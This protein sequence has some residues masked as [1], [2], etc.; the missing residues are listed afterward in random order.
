MTTYR[1]EVLHIAL[2]K[3][4]VSFVH[5]TS[6]HSPTSFSRLESH[7]QMKTPIVVL[8]KQIFLVKLVFNSS[9]C[10]L[11]ADFEAIVTLVYS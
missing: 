10:F 8:A 11:R 3:Y 7:I 1:S 5:N 9:E 4:I 2:T 6:H